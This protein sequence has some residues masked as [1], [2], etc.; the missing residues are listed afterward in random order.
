MK[1]ILFIIKK[2]FYVLI[3]MERK[4]IV[5]LLLLV[6]MI[7][8]GGLIATLA[9]MPQTKIHIKPNEPNENF[10]AHPNLAG[11]TYTNATVISDGYND[12]WGWNTNQSA[13]PAI[14]VDSAGNL[15]V[16]WEDGTPGKWGPGYV[17]DDEP[18]TDLE[19][20]YANFSV[21]TGKWSNITV[22]SDGYNDI[23]GWNTNQSTDAEIALDGK[24][25]IHVIWED[26]SPGAWGEGDGI[27][28]A[29]DREI[30]YVLYNSSTSE[31][32]NI[33]ILSDGPNEQYGWNNR[34]SEDPAIAVDSSDNVHVVFQD[35]T[36]GKWNQSTSDDEIMYVLYNSTTG[37][38]SNITVISDGYNDFYWNDG[39]SAN[40][41]I[42]VDGNDDIHVAWEDETNGKWGNDQE[43][44]YAKYSVA[45]GQWSNATVLSDGYN[46][47]WG[48]NDGN[49]DDIHMASDNSGNVYIVWE[50][51]TENLNKWGDDTEVMFVEYSAGTGQWSNVSVISDGYN[52]VWGWNNESSNDAN[53]AVDCYGN[54]HVLWDDGT[55]GKWGTDKEIMYA[56]RSA[57]SGKWSNATVISDGAN[58]NYGWNTEDSHDPWIV[59]NS[60]EVHAVFSDNT[61]GKWGAGLDYSDYIP[62]DSEIMYVK[63]TIPPPIGLPADDDD[64][65]DED[66]EIPLWIVILV[67]GGIA[68]AGIA[69]LVILMKKDIIFK[70]ER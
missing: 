27:W 35:E 29:N 64:D 1:D 32:S 24:D 3:K 37:Q 65:D 56:T 67:I 46:G 43:L 2:K 53:I 15:H 6:Y 41:A 66:E 54:L 49:M 62:D 59:I 22:L 17:D 34:D 48:W 69:V 36:D 12:I 28:G 8:F 57:A 61:P 52:G 16:V 7:I 45:T 20:M 38:W 63:I 47:V 42:T 44:M 40:P 55:I 33:T 13:I 9:Y 25:N 58:G 70:K 30:M 21:A 68:G 39:Q 50:D 31:W 18:P 11:V 19:I 14:D 26:Y 4:S 5:R 60:N 23:W 10:P 51:F